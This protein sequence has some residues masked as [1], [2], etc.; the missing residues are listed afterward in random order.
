MGTNS[1]RRKGANTRQMG[2][3]KRSML[4]NV[5]VINT[6]GARHGRCGEGRNRTFLDPHG[7]P[8]AVLKIARGTSHPTLSDAEAKG[9]PRQRQHFAGAVT[10]RDRFD[11]LGYAD[12]V[13]GSE[14][15]SVV[16]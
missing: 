15:E 9:V 13:R 5:L 8:T 12:V 7:K 4:R 16:S 11:L 6:C 14:C 2:P 1:M 10:R 3:S